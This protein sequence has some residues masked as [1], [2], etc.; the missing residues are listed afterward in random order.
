VA[1]RPSEGEQ[2][3]FDRASAHD[4]ELVGERVELLGLSLVTTRLPPTFTRG[5]PKQAFGANANDILSRNTRSRVPNST[6]IA[7][8]GTAVT[9]KSLPQTLPAT[10]SDRRPS[11]KS[12]CK[13]PSSGDSIARFSI[14]CQPD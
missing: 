6:R 12:V 11:N 1:Q 5:W 10:G 14:N 7:F 2:G 3:A 4:I 9:L 13:G 8:F